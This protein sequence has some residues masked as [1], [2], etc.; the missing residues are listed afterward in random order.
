MIYT[1]STMNIFFVTIVLTL[2]S[3]WCKGLVNYILL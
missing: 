2:C 3:L 1:K